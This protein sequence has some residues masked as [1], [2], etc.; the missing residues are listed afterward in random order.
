MYTSSF[1]GT[2]SLW[3][4]TLQK[5][6]GLIILSLVGIKYFDFVLKY[7]QILTCFLTRSLHTVEYIW[8]TWDMDGFPTT[9]RTPS[10]TDSVLRVNIK[11][12]PSWVSNT[13]YGSAKE[14]CTTGEPVSKGM[15]W[16][17]LTINKRKI[18]TEVSIR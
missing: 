17:C 2:N 12:W 11:I 5:K 13:M 1:L 10:P 3:E 14:H 15:C 6:N 7:P 9:R 4:N 8:P 18:S 16:I